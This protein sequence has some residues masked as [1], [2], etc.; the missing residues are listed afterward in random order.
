MSALAEFYV[1]ESGGLARLSEAARKRG[2]LRKRGGDVA[3]T[4]GKVARPVGGSD[5]SGYDYA[6]L[7]AYLD[8]EAVPLAPPEFDDVQAA[9]ADA[10][11]ASPILVMPSAA[12]ALNALDDAE[13]SE[14]QF[15]S[16]YEA[17]NE[18][19]DP[20]AG[21]RLIR[22]LSELRRRAADLADEEALVI[23]LG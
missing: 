9:I 12:E 5:G 21:I 15:R 16:Y 18:V 19:E 6:V 8:E 17:F 22:A 14:S 11:E 1:V 4:F 10:T 13:H 20:E 7:V 2:V 23:I 3:G